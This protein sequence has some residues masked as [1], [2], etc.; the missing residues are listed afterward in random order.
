MHQTNIMAQKWGSKPRL[1][2]HFGGAQPSPVPPKRL[3]LI[4]LLAAAP[5]AGA[6]A[7]D[8]AVLWQVAGVTLTGPAALERGPTGVFWN[9]AAV[10][11]APGLAGGLEVLHT[12]EVVSLDGLLGALTYR[13]GRGVAVG[14]TA[15]RI[16]VADLVRT[17]TSPIGE[18]EI[19]VYSQFV[20]AAAGTSIGPLRLGTQLRLHDGRIDFRADDGVTLDVGIRLEPVGP[21]VLA[22]ASHFATPRFEGLATTDYYAAAEYRI[23]TSQ[24]WGEPAVISGRYGVGLRG[25]GEL[26]HGVSAGLSF[27]DRLRVDGGFQRETAYDE[28]AWR[29]TVGLAFRAGRYVIAA[30]RGSGLNEI[31]AAYRIGL[32]AGLI[33]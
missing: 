2:R 14:V 5:P 23:G 30:A 18:G 7:P 15:G 31:G 11:D 3:A 1:D 20:G 24:V 10:V 22:A 6:Q 12:P 13:F 29:L 4:S 27:G 32:T 28:T 26:E 17:T 19:P 9:P 25:T 21:L 33:R 8:W 16:S